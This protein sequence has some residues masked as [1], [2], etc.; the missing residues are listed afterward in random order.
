MAGLRLR[1]ES[2]GRVAGSASRLSAL[3]FVLWLNGCATQPSAPIDA[4]QPRE[5]VTQPVRPPPPPVA[6][7]TVNRGDTLYAIAFARGLDFRDIARWN[8]IE[9]PF[10]IYP[11]QRLRLGPSDPESAPAA[12]A[13]TA[14]PSVAGPGKASVRVIERVPA[15]AVVMPS[16]GREPIFVPLDRSDAKGS[17]A[18]DKAAQAGVGAAPA[19]SQAAVAA[20]ASP[21]SPSPPTATAVVAA[22]DPAA[23]TAGGGT[24]S[25]VAVSERPVQQ[26]AAGKWLWPTD[27]KVL[28][29]FGSGGRKGVVVGGRSG[30]PIRATRAGEVVYAG[31]GLLGYGLLV[32]VK[33]DDTFLSA[34]GNNSRLLV[35]EGARIDAGQS[36]AE[37]G[38]SAD[39]R[40]GLHFE[41]RRKGQPIDPQTLVQAP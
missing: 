25:E 2:S 17:A 34:Y 8:G 28:E 6:S 31:G 7:V 12:V 18:D 20:S 26:A 37:M 10:T 39:G 4:P 15:P 38:A 11:G 35:K 27:G 14:Q 19:G 30:Q 13:A 22:V 24:K 36:I 5:T 1:P 16:A 33:H 29:A 3:V 9:A 40:V 32:I 21:A 41:L 23:S